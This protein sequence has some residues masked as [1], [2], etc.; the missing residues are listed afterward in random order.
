LLNFTGE[1]EY[2]CASGVKGSA[3]APG[4]QSVTGWRTWCSPK[5][6]G[7]V[8]ARPFSIKAHRVTRLQAF[9]EAMHLGAVAG[10]K[11]IDRLSL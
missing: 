4:L 3:R 7:R 5:G 6:D 2:D 1:R 9:L 10:I 8:N 11:E